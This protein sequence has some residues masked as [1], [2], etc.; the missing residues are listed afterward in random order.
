MSPELLGNGQPS[1]EEMARMQMQMEQEREDRQTAQ[2]LASEAASRQG[3]AK[4]GYWSIIGQPDIGRDNGTDTLEEYSATEFSNTF[5]LGNIS[6]SDWQSLGW[7]IETE[8]WTMRNEFKDADTAMG[9]DDMRIM[10]GD[11]RP[12]LDDEKARRLRSAGEAK[13]MYTSGSIEARNLRA[14]TEI[15][16]VA[17]TENQDQENED[18]TRLGK[19]KSALV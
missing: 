7:R 2:S 17:K 19:F 8:F 4:D 12:T 18:E 15:H 9:D 10:Y 13:K 11:D 16:A 6:R 5:A 3:E 14:G 1:Q